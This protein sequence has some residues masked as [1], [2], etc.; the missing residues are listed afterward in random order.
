MSRKR[1]EIGGQGG[2]DVLDLLAN[3]PDVSDDQTLKYEYELVLWAAGQVRGEF[4]ESSWKAF[5]MTF[6]DGRSVAEV[7]TELGVTPGS[8]YVSRSRIL[9]R[10]RAIVREVLDE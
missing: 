1:R 4:L 9:A 8:I 5:W 10:I 6:V 3:V 7:A 2:T